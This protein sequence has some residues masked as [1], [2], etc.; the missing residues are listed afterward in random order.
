LLEEED[1]KSRQAF[2]K[3]TASQFRQAVRFQSLRG[4]GER[5][6]DAMASRRANSR[7]IIPV[8]KLVALA[9]L[10]IIFNGV[11]A[12]PYAHA[13]TA[14]SPGSSQVPYATGDLPDYVPG[15][16]IIGL[17]GKPIETL[18]RFLDSWNAKI[19]DELPEINAYLIRIG[20]PSISAIQY[21]AKAFA[22]FDYVEPNYY[23]HAALTPNDP[24]WGEQWGLP[25]V[26]ADLAWDI[27]MGTR[28]MIV[29]VI[30]T[31]IDYL[32]ADLAAN[33][34]PLGY[35]W[36][37]GD[38]DPIDDSST[39]HG[40]HVAGII[41]AV[42]NNGVDVAGLAQVSIM[43]EK[44]L[45]KTGAGTIFDV[46]QGVIDAA[47]KGARITNNSYETDIYS[48]TM[49]AAFEYAW[50][51]GVLNVAAAGNDNKNQPFYPAAFT[52]FV[53]S[54]S[55]TDQTDGRY[56]SSNYGDW[57]ELSAPAVDIVSTLPGNH[58]GSLTGTSASSAFAAG[59]AALVWSHCGA[60][61]A[62]EVRQ[63]LRETAVDLG[64]P[65]RDPFFGYGRMDAFS[66]LQRPCR[67]FAVGGRI[68]EPEWRA[69]PM[70][71]ME[72]ALATI[73]VGSIAMLLR[74]ACLRSVGKTRR[75]R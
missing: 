17:G 54:V 49:R 62:E 48:D 57:V 11:V 15:E 55:G 4:Q 61:S 23:V 2:L 63:R 28:S 74:H 51:Q 31:G 41:G 72:V 18:Q 71:V 65:G 59:A 27:E 40:T 45:D 66:A 3:V 22:G 32:H 1:V 16:M 20:E 33:Y 29:A 69:L 56:S 26:R 47:K 75:K 37:N 39:G 35:D 34:V 14:T 19:V 8:T 10:V 30:D 13:L 70:P 7:H 73:A 25:K 21:E 46:G 12:G 53:I 58:Y 24:R 6:T 52:E 64:A 60:I 50:S 42:T 68:L 44:V 36:V 38:N 43:A 5:R 67:G 9:L